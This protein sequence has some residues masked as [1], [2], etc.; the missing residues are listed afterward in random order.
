MGPKSEAFGSLFL[1]EISLF[2]FVLQVLDKMVHVSVVL[3]H[4]MFW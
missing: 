2:Y 3:C 4:K 1:I